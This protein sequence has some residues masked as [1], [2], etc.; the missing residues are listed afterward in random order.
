[1]PQLTANHLID[2]SEVP[3]LSGRSFASV[4]PASAVRVNC[5]SEGGQSM[6]TKSYELNPLAKCCRSVA[7]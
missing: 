2:G 5:P 6:S 7:V 4:E 1:M 3:S